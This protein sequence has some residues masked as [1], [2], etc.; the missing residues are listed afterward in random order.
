MIA[1]RLFCRSLRTELS[2]Q[3]V[4][5]VTNLTD[6]WLDFGNESVSDF[7][8]YQVRRARGVAQRLVERRGK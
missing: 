1:F 2:S 5:S 7:L 8:V 3:E 4:C 6:S